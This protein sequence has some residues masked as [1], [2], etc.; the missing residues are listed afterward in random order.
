MEVEVAS[1][2]DEIIWDVVQSKVPPLVEQLEA[3]LR[4]AGYSE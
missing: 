2:D 3:E 1:M 4:S